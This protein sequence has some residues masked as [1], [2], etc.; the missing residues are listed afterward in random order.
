MSL[1][2]NKRLNVIWNS[3]NGHPCGTKPTLALV[4]VIT[5]SA[6]TFWTGTLWICGLP[7]ARD[8]NN[9][10]HWPTTPTQSVGPT[11]LAC[12]RGICELG[13]WHRAYMLLQPPH[14]VSPIVAQMPC[15][16]CPDKHSYPKQTKRAWAPALCPPQI[17]FSAWF[18]ATFS[19]PV[20]LSSAHPL[21]GAFPGRCRL[22]FSSLHVQCLLSAIKDPGLLRYT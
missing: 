7:F 6:C 8:D 19:H 15:V 16:R 10:Q 9:P 3:Y 12:H 13:N 18:S 4:H 14:M 21:L 17:T 5:C 20:V 1:L 2:C 22:P 11:R